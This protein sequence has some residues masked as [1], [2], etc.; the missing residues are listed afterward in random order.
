M[1]HIQCEMYGIEVLLE[2]GMEKQDI[3]NV[4][5]LVKHNQLETLQ[6][7]AE[8]LRDEIKMLEIEKTMSKHRVVRLERMMSSL[9]Q[10]R[11]MALINQESTRCDNTGN[12]YPIPY[13]EPDSNSP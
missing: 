13:S 6:S 7:K 1:Y 9:V 4:L 11:D 5:D 10:K 2:V 8:N 12:L 3:I